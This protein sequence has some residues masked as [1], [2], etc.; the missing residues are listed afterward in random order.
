MNSAESRVHSGGI[1][2]G[3][4]SEH[5]TTLSSTYSGNFLWVYI[6]FTTFTT[7]LKVKI[8][9]TTGKVLALLPQDDPMTSQVPST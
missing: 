7:S 5:Q 1:R 4:I 6:C 2:W 9:S 8:I 3:D